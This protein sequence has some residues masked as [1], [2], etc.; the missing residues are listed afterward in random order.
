MTDKY[1]IPLKNY[2]RQYRPSS[3]EVIL[4]LGKDNMYVP[5]IPTSKQEK[6]TRRKQDFGYQAKNIADMVEHLGGIILDSVWLNNT[7]R[8][9]VPTSSL[10]QI[11]EI[12]NVE[13]I[14]IART[15]KAE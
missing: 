14:D 1:T 11:A 13:H 4:E 5:Y 3:I 9:Q 10:E 12:S 7:I 6:I 8:V 2:L 15:I